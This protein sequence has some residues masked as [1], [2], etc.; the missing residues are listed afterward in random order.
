QLQQ[1]LLPKQEEL[2]KIEGLE[3]AGFMEPADE[4]GGDYYDVLQQNGRAKISIGD[5]TGHGLES[6]VVMIMAQTAVRT[7]QESHQTD[8]VQFLDILN[9]TI[10]RNIQRIN[11]YKNLTLSILDYADNTLTVSGQHEEIIV[12]RSGGKVERL[13]TRYLGF[14]LGLEEEIADFI[15]QEQVRLNLGDVVVLYTDGVTEAFNINQEQ[16][17]LERLCEVVKQNSSLSAEEIREAVIADVRQ[18]I[19]KQKVFDDITLVVIKQK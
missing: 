18:H 5:V 13:D 10:Y 3:I 7:L 9:R 19:G 16:Y 14:P 17:G 1:M 4:V 11:P 6:G 8:P 12:V 2:E 15:A